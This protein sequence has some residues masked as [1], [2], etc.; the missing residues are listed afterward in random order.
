MK[1]CITIAALLLGLPVFASGDGVLEMQS[2]LEGRLRPLVRELDPKALVYVTVRTKSLDAELP[3][4]PFVYRDYVLEGPEGEML[5]QRID[6]TVYSDVTEFPPSFKKVVRE[7]SGIFAPL[8]RLSVKHLP[9]EFSSF[10]ANLKQTRE[11]AE[12]GTTETRKPASNEVTSRWRAAWQWAAGQEGW[13]LWAMTGLLAAFGCAGLFFRALRRSAR[14]V[15]STMER[16]ID[17]MAKTLE[18]A[19]ADRPSSTIAVTSGDTNDQRFRD[20]SDDAWD[21]LLTDCYWSDEDGYAAFLWPRIPFAQRRKLL[22]R[23]PFLASYASYLANVKALDLG[24]EREP[25]YHAP[26]PIG[27][28]DNE[29]VAALVREAPGLILRLSSLRVASLPLGQDERLAL[30]EDAEQR[31]STALPDFASFP[32]S[33]PRPLA[34]ALPLR[35]NETSPDKS[36]LA[37]TGEL[38]LPLVRSVPSL[39]W[40]LRLTTEEATTILQDTTAE[41]LAA[42]WIGPEDLLAKIE[43]LLPTPT[44]RRLGELKARTTPSRTSASFR[45]LHQR[46]VAALEARNGGGTAARRAA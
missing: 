31:S 11:V 34:R 44:A 46:I 26:F 18:R 15:T 1:R 42:A 10:A 22:E 13:P 3:S 17:R 45:R 6:I 43:R 35:A 19:V 27:A 32:V 41:D 40:I 29:S 20:F 38:S 25:Y 5:V 8:T 28:L 7:L 14:E 16:G 12:R 9:N 23:R 21:A 36:V 30:L 37:Q 24:F 39:A 33:V 4:T 2:L